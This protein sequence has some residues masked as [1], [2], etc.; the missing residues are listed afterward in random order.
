MRKIVV[1][2][3][4]AADLTGRSPHLPVPG[5]TVMGSGF[6]I[7][8]GGKGSNQAV[9]AHRAGGDVVMVTKLGLDVFG[10]AVTDFYEAEGMD[11]S[12][13]FRDESQDTNLAM[14][15]VDE[16]TAQNEIVVIGG[17]CTN[18]TENSATIVP[19]AAPF[20]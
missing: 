5:E 3:S 16:G 4:A 2:G 20:A 15:L 18:I 8:P 13:L 7:S 10:K 6:G 12:Y 11:I 17:A 19:K 1:F 14:I 9:A